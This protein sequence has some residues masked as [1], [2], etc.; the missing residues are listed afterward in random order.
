MYTCIHT[1]F[2]THTD[3]SKFICFMLEM[4]I[5]NTKFEN[6]KLCVMIHYIVLNF[7]IPEGI[8]GLTV[9]KYFTGFFFIL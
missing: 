7:F 2:P 3:M 6:K 8:L 5:M 1:H 9:H 4:K